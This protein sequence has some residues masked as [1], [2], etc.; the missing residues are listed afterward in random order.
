VERASLPHRTSSCRADIINQPGDGD[1]EW[2]S[3]GIWGGLKITQSNLKV[4]VQGSYI[5]VAMRPPVKAHTRNPRSWRARSG[6]LPLP[7]RSPRRWGQWG[8]IPRG[9]VALKFATP[10]NRYGYALLHR[11]EVRAA[12]RCYAKWRTLGEC[13]VPLPSR[14]REKVAKKRT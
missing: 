14:R 11:R 6:S 1:K 10:V 9:T 3:A 4:E 8:S 2:A 12:R 5:L 7:A 13:Q